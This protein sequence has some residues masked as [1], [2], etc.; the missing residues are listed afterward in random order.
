MHRYNTY[1]VCYLQFTNPK[2][3]TCQHLY[4]NINCVDFYGFVCLYVFALDW[5]FENS[6]I[7]AGFLHL[8]TSGHHEE[9]PLP[10]PLQYRH[11]GL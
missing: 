8:W 9:E 5:V 3:P 4:N 1:F 2:L 7:D 11:T 10:L 6:D